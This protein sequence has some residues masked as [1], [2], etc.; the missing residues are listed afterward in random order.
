[1][2]L[3]QAPSRVP[4]LIP[5]RHGRMLVSP[6]TFYRGAALVMAADLAGTPTS[7]LATQVLDGRAGHHR[8]RASGRACR[9]WTTLMRATSDIFLGLLRAV[10]TDGNEEDYYD[11]QLRDWKVSAERDHATLAAAVESE[12]ARSSATCKPGV[13]QHVPTRRNEAD[14]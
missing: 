6:F 4:E 2:L 1:L 12:P 10:R 14:R 9:R 5:I 11:R 3:G 13:V 7:G 8:P